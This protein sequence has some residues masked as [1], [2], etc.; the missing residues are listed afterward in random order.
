MET[1]ALLLFTSLPKEVLIRICIALKR[2]IVPRPGLNP[3][4]LGPL[5]STITASQPRAT[6]QA[7]SFR[8]VTAEARFRCQDSQCYIGGEQSGT[9]TLFS[10]IHSV[11]LS[12]YHSTAATS[13]LG[14][15]RCVH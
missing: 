3:R 1:T 9:G 13:S 10:R 8:L 12:H 2:N 4:T 6:V 7:V 11:F 5:A 14:A 15:R